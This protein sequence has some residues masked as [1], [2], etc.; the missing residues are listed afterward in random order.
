MHK[1]INRKHFKTEIGKYALS[2]I[3]SFVLFTLRCKGSQ[4]EKWEV[5]EVT[6]NS[7]PLFW[8]NWNYPA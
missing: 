1:S 3:K 2:S 4:L 8:L 5:M 7:R 6:V